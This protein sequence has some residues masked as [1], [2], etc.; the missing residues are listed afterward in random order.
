[1][2]QSIS[3]AALLI[4]SAV[5]P[6]CFGGL[7]P[8][9]ACS[10]VAVV[11]CAKV[12]ECVSEAERTA[13]GF[14]SESGCVTKIKNDAGCAE[15]T[16][17]NACEGSLVFDGSAAEDCIE[18]AEAASCGQWKDNAADVDKIA[19]ACNNVCAAE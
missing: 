19:P 2:N 14:S 16:E 3:I 7:T 1:M 12:F 11:T 13:A 5:L 10:E 18:Q 15:K 8:D 4:L 9:E 6:A 17:E